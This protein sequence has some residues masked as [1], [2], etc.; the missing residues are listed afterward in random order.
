MKGFKGIKWPMA[1]NYD[2]VSVGFNLN[3][4]DTLIDIDAYDGSSK[5]RAA[6]AVSIPTAKKIVA[7]LQR[8]ISEVG[9]KE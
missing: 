1:R 4:E 7:E 6:C 8:L 9:V 3:G 2:R 5:E